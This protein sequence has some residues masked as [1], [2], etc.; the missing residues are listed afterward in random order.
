MNHILNNVVFHILNGLKDKE[1]SYHADQTSRP[2]FGR[3]GNEYFVNNG[4]LAGSVEIKSVDENTVKC[5]IKVSWDYKRCKYEF[6]QTAQEDRK[7]YGIYTFTATLVDSTQIVSIQEV[8][9]I[10]FDKD[11]N[12]QQRLDINHDSAKYAKAGLKERLIQPLSGHLHLP[13][14]R[15]SLIRELKESNNLVIVN[16]VNVLDMSNQ[17]HVEGPV[18]AVGDNAEAHH[19]TLNQFQNK[20]N[21]A[22]VAAEIQQLLEQLE[23]SY[24]TDT[25][26]QKMTVA[27]EA[28]KQIESNPQLIQKIVSALK[29]GSTQALAQALNHPLASF[30]IS[31]FEDWQKNKGN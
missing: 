30:M 12:F 22:E 24:P 19:F 14:D 29:A 2:T 21:L 13:I 20:H 23:K 8:D 15:N 17:Y 3:Q 10:P 11:P 16:G 26:S 6:I 7:D 9:W 28:I 1:F 31:A 5:S 27:L 25:T 18:G 4:R